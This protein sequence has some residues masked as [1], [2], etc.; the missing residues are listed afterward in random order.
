[1]QVWTPY[2]NPRF[3]TLSYLPPLT[4]EQ[5]AKQVEYII[6]SGWIPCLE[7]DRI[8][9]VYRKHF[10][11]SGY[12]DGR[13]WTMWKLP[14]FGCNDAAAVLREIDECIKAYPDC[15]VRILGFDSKRQVQVSGFVAHKPAEPKPFNP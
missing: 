8:G 10:F 15:Y 11:G 7:F 1:M 13:Y 12:A 5:A 6:R 3:E 4:K 2:E 9:G 14:M